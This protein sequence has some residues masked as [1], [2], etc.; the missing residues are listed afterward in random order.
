MIE[1]CN[2][3]GLTSHFSKF[4]DIVSQLPSLHDLV[5]FYSIVNQEFPFSKL[6]SYAKSIFVLERFFPNELFQVRCI[7]HFI[8][9]TALG[10]F[11]Y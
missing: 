10:L 9:G 11:K 4:I 7:C 2:I 5:D 8:G 6:M 1:K 3:Y